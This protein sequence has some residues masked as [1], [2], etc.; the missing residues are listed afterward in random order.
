[1]K[2]IVI[3]GAKGQL[4]QELLNI[5]SKC[6]SELG[7]LNGFYSKCKLIPLDVDELD[8]TDLFETI[9][10]IKKIK[11]YAV[12]NCAAMTNVDGCEDNEELAL[13]IN[14]LGPRNLAMACRKVN[15]KLIQISTD[16]IFS[17]DSGR[18]YKET[19]IPSP[20]SVYGA[21]KYLGEEYVKDFCSK[22]FIIRTSWLYGY[23]G[24]N[25]VKTI[26]KKAKKDGKLTV[27]DDQ[28]GNPTN[29]ADLAYM[30]AKIIPTKEYGIY[31]CT[32]IGECS[33]YDF[34][35]EIVKCFKIE[36]EVLPC[37]TEQSNRKAN[38]PAYSSLDNEMLRVTV[39]DEMRPWKE[40][41]KYFSENI[42]IE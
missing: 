36:A 26:V 19:D 13:K 16:Y 10:I 24:N 11:P 39:K 18:P 35:C 12:I 3:C 28:V 22:W 17:G 8:I 2:K 23:Y 38:R 25:F 7:Q 15:A 30:I 14:S 6:K 34:A 29:A 5:M 9:K 40:A 27:V 32:G 31:N 1:M 20:K 4:G 42:I 21:T 41:L 33:W 37:K